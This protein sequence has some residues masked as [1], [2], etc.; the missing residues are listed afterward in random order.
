MISQDR[1]TSRKSV[2]AQSAARW[3]ERNRDA[4]VDT[5][6]RLL[7]EVNQLAAHPP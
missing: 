2:T 4:D 3:R 7:F 1:E 6:N 5:V